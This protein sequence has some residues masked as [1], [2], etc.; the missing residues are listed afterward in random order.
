MAGFKSGATDDDWGDTGYDADDP[1]EQTD[2]E[3]TDETS[4]DERKETEADS[5]M[6]SDSTG[7]TTRQQL[8][9]LPW[10]LTRNNITDGRHKTVQLHL[11]TSTIDTQR[12]A[13]RSVEDRLGENVKKADLREAALL[14]GLQHTTEIESILRD[15]G[16]AIEDR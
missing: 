11:Q 9:D 3:S 13:R 16:Y 4:L 10:V 2:G 1:A 6:E 14:V 5:A 15:W 7:E 8:T 12:D